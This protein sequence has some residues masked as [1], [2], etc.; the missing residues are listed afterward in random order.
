MSRPASANPDGTS[1]LR[2][3]QPRGGGAA[4]EIIRNLKHL[5][6]RTLRRHHAQQT[7]SAPAN[8]CAD[9]GQFLTIHSPCRTRQ[10]KDKRVQKQKYRHQ[11]TTYEPS[12]CSALE[13]PGGRIDAPVPAIRRISSQR[14]FPRSG[15]RGCRRCLLHDGTTDS[16]GAAQHPWCHVRRVRDLPAMPRADLGRLPLRHACSTEGRGPERREYW[17]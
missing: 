7:P 9:I 5:I 13:I 3:E 15:R 8:S 6:E 12:N 4:A 10:P 16:G 14:R 17:L 1:R 11:R 2:I